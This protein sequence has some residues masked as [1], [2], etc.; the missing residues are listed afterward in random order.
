MY[1]HVLLIR[2]TSWVWSKFVSQVLNEHLSQFKSSRTLNTSLFSSYVHMYV[3]MKVYKYIYVCM[4]VY[5]NSRDRHPQIAWFC[6]DILGNL[7]LENKIQPNH[8]AQY[9]DLYTGTDRIASHPRYSDE[10]FHI[11]WTT[12]QPFLTQRLTSV[13]SS[14][15]CVKYSNK[16]SLWT[17]KLEGTKRD[18]SSKSISIYF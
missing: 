6:S 3:Y 7:I 16:L 18:T 12:R 15:G 8:W 13:E 17:P 9:S 1:I 5:S 10:G 2:I 11:K 4:Y 14:Y